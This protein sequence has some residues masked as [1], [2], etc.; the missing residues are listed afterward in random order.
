MKKTNINGIALEYGV[1]SNIEEYTDLDCY[2]SRPGDECEYLVRVYREKETGD[3]LGPFWRKSENKDAPFEDVMEL[4]DDI[5]DSYR[6]AAR[7]AM[8]L[9]VDEIEFAA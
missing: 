8:R 6:C 2:L 1:I 4:E 7:A 5:P 3:I 9:F